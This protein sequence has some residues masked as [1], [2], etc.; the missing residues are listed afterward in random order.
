MLQ[1]HKLHCFRV[2]PQILALFLTR[3]N[4]RA[5]IENPVF[6]D[7]EI[8]DPRLLVRLQSSLSPLILANVIDRLYTRKLWEKVHHHSQAKIKARTRQLHSKLRNT[9]VFL[10]N[11]SV[12]LC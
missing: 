6:V 12:L 9:K 7:W 2:S 3:A 11:S 1:A 4:R 8:Q 10:Q 5:G